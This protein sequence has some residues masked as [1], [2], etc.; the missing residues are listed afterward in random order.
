MNF[1]P[2]N[3]E[4]SKQALFDV[5]QNWLLMVI[6]R[7]AVDRWGT[8]GLPSLLPQSHEVRAL[9]HPLQALQWCQ[10]RKCLQALV[11]DRVGAQVTRVL[12]RV[13]MIGRGVGRHGF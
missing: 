2:L 9:L 3:F 12:W 8:V 11:A 13:R 5:V 6:Q 4:R 10:L 1:S 7:L